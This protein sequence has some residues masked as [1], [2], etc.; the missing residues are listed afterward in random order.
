MKLTNPPEVASGPMYPFR[1]SLSRH[2]T[3]K[4]TWPLR[5][6]GMLAITRF[7]GI[8][9]HYAGR[10]EVEDLARVLA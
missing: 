10:F 1:Y 3:S 4:V 8:P 2:S 9:R 7:Y 5:S 6:S